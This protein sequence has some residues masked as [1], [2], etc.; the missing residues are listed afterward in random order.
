[1]TESPHMT[2]SET[3]MTMELLDEARH[4]IGLHY[5]GDVEMPAT[6]SI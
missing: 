5:P 1:M 2:T 3:V 6:V 4:Q